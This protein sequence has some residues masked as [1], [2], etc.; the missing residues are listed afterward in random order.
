MMLGILLFVAV[1]FVVAF[2][3][4]FRKYSSSIITK[5]SVLSQEDVAEAESRSRG[6]AVSANTSQLPRANSLIARVNSLELGR[7]SSRDFTYASVFD[8]KE[9]MPDVEMTNP[10]GNIRKCSSLLQRFRICNIFICTR[11]Y[12]C[13]CGF[14]I[15]VILFAN[16]SLC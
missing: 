13:D 5:E 7:A 12:I 15:L 4:L 14:F 9:I 3:L 11:I 2:F 8:E 16:N 1:T 6:G 10:Y